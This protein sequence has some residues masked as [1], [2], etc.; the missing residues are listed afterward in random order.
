MTL[1]TFLAF[2]YFFLILSDVTLT[3]YLGITIN[4]IV[5]KHYLSTQR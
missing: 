3:I 5:L 1:E 4:R 2:L